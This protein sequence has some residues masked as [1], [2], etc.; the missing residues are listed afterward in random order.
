[1]IGVWSEWLSFPD[2]RA[3]HPL[4]APLGP[5]VYDSGIARRAG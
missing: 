4:V 3:G 2:P 5:G 1:M